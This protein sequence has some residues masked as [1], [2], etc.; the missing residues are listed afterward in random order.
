MAGKTG[1]NIKKTSQL[2]EQRV[3]TLA[4]AR[5]AKKRKS[6]RSPLVT[7]EKSPTSLRAAINAKCYD[8]EGQNHD[9]KWQ[10][11]VGNCTIPSCPLYNVRPY[12]KMEGSPVPVAL[13]GTPYETDVLESRDAK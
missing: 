11:R 3:A 8:C 5:A 6:K 2:Y 12:Q 10:W 13:G 9:P 1:Q 7:A 4:K